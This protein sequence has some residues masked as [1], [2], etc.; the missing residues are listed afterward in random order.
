[1]AIFG[2]A[3]AE[4]VARLGLVRTLRELGLGLD[5]IRRVLQREITIADV[6]AAH[7]TALDAQIRS[8]RLSRAVLSTVAQRRPDTEE[9][10]LMNKLAR[11]SAQER[12]QIIEDFVAEFFADL[13]ADPQLKDKMLHNTPELPDDPTPQQVDAW[14]ELVELVT[15]SDFRQRMRTMVRYQPKAARSRDRPAKP[16]RTCGSPKRSRRWW[17]RHASAASPRTHPRKPRSSTGLSP[18][19]TQPAGT[20]SWSGCPPG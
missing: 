3:H 2:T 4:S 17:V 19:Q 5:E 13:D 7:V 18:V 9:M 8:L 10:T 11:L 14:V 12:R 1:M 6:A 20:T 16:A 15:D